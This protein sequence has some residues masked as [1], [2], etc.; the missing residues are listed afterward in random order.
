MKVTIV[1]KN[2]SS[3]IHWE[4]AYLIMNFTN[5]KRENAHTALGTKKFIN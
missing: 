2:I 4:R 3:I 1:N 5:F